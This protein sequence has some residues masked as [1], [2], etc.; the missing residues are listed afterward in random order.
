M[1]NWLDCVDRDDVTLSSS[2]CCCCSAEQ[3]HHHQPQQQ[4]H[5]HYQRYPAPDPAD[6]RLLDQLDPGQAGFNMEYVRTP[7]LYPGQTDTPLAACSSQHA[8][9]HVHSSCDVMY[10][11]DSNGG[12][13]RK[14]IELR[15]SCLVDS[16]NTTSGAC[17]DINMA[18]PER[19]G[20]MDQLTSYVEQQGS[21]DTVSR[22]YSLSCY[23]SVVLPLQS[24][25]CR[26][27]VT[28]STL[29][30]HQDNCHLPF[31]PWMKR[32]HLANGQYVSMCA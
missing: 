3:H 2:N 27:D 30:R 16:D 4:Q 19:G 1:E 6:S 7:H 23:G 9:R 13:N 25:N 22:D 31:Y 5:L 26:G 15:T 20:F 17:D 14:Y 28:N 10:D 11:D 29:P 18:G 12:Y 21:R 24:A 8:V 32:V